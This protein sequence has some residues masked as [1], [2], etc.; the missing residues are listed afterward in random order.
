MNLEKFIVIFLLYKINRE[1]I[2]YFIMYLNMKLRCVLVVSKK[3]EVD[4]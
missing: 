1:I 3:I 2:F 4:F